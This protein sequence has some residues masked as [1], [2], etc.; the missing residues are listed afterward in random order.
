MAQKSLVIVESPAKAKTINKYLGKEFMVTASV[1][2]IIDLPKTKLGVNLEKDFAPQYVNIR[3]KEKVIKDLRAQ[4]K[5]SDQVF[6]AT[7]PDREGEAIAFHIATVLEKVNTNIL[8]VEF[9]EITKNAVDQA[10]GHPRAIDMSR[11][12]SQQARR[13][14]DRIVGYQVSPVLW[15]TVHRGL[16]AG[17]VQ[18]VALRL[19]CEREQE[20]RVFKPEEYWTITAEVQSAGSDPLTVKLAKIDSKKAKIPNQESSDK[21]E[22]AIRASELKIS[23]VEKKATKRQ[24]G[25]PFITSTL[26]Q[27]ASSRLR[28]STKRIMGIAQSLY[29]G[30]VVPGQGSIGLITYMRTDSFRVSNEALQAASEYIQQT[31]DKS[32]GLEKARHFRSK[33]NAQDA[34]EAIRPTYISAEFAPEAL[35]PHLSNEQYRLYDLIWKRFIASQMAP[36]VIDKTMILVSAGTSYEFSAEGETVRFPGYMR[37]YQEEQE[38]EKNNKQAIPS[39]LKQGASCELLELLPQQNFTK[40]VPRFS[41]STLVKELDKLNIGRP[42]TYAQIVSTILRRKYVRLEERKLHATELGE[43]VNKIL[44]TNLADFFNVSFTAKMEEQ[45]DQIA[46]NHAT[47]EEV[48]HGFYDPFHQ[49]LEEVNA[50]RKEIKADLT[51]ESDQTCDKCGKPML[52]RWGRNGRFLACSGFPECKITK[53]LDGD[54]QPQESDEK[55]PKCDKTMLIKTGPFGKFLACSDYPTCKTT[56]PLGTGVACPKDGCNGEVI[57]RRSKRGKIFF[58]CS[59]YP[60]CD[61]VSWDKPVHQACPNCEHHYLLE[62]TTKAK[63]TFLRCPSCKHEILP[64]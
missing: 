29:E 59:K 30:V 57:Q 35:K 9:N 34:H 41:E 11:V 6:I 4:A 15:K 39:G 52:V 56:K 18:S 14:L 20:I 48:M 17:R 63:G 60:K 43:T 5:K 49:A 47:Y 12:Y 13:V 54:E 33:K 62:K 53:P 2:H 32:H 23:A 45:L 38:L 61:F 19:I 31:F 27:T 8:R 46:G 1:G 28:Y 58:G 64:E 7:D 16:S 44:V 40:P 50:R 3:G 37:V 22:A 24:P 55:C 51:E 25:P 26:Q 36:A 42:S 10:M 21:H